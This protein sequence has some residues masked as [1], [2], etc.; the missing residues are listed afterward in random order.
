MKNCP[1]GFAKSVY[2]KRLIL[3]ASSA[4]PHGA[5]Y[6]TV[7][8]ARI[9]AVRRERDRELQ[10]VRVT[11]RHSEDWRRSGCGP[12]RRRAVRDGRIVVVGG[13]RPD[14]SQTAAHSCVRHLATQTR[15]TTR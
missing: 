6:S 2:F 15:K 4:P 8:Q 3:Q 11:L 14:H 12:P 5:A 10:G 1:C 9:R 13:G 7:A